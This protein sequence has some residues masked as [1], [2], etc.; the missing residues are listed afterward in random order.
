MALKSFRS[1]S[2]LDRNL[3]YLSNVDRDRS[4]SR[5]AFDFSI[6]LEEEIQDVVSI[7][8]IGYNFNTSM[9]PTFIGKYD[10]IT[11]ENVATN[12]RSPLAAFKTF[13]IRVYA[14]NDIDFVD[15]P[16]DME[17]INLPSYD[18]SFANAPLQFLFFS[19]RVGD[20]VDR[21]LAQ[22]GNAFVNSANTTFTV[23]INEQLTVD[24]IFYRTAFPNEPMRSQMIFD[25]SGFDIQDQAAGALGYENGTV[26]EST[27]STLY[28]AVGSGINQVLTAPFGVNEQFMR[29]VNVY[30]E[31]AAEF[32]PLSRLYLTRYPGGQQYN[33]ARKD[34]K[35]RI[36][37]N[38]LRR[39]NRLNIRMTIGDDYR[40]PETM[41]DDVQLSFEI[42]SVKPISKLPEWVRQAFLI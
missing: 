38:T 5:S 26:V 11:A 14:P 13:K 16:V 28:P 41:P 37:S 39:L 6:E 4:R 15:L 9:I 34:V 27:L 21:T 1:R 8:L 12:A 2:Y 29:Y 42:L 7:E 17:S 40:I 18:Y 19:L 24:F 25:N 10:Y 20:Q 32:S 22:F 33:I 36:L 31:E 35:P 23:D 30:V 3:V